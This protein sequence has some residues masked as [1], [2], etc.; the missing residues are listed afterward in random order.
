MVRK[1]NYRAREQDVP[2]D[3]R[4]AI[5]L[6]FCLLTRVD[7]VRKVGFG[8]EREK[9]IKRRRGQPNDVLLKRG[10]DGGVRFHC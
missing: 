5:V 10:K 9:S 7:E 6:R 4:C 2:V 3:L 8:V 1:V